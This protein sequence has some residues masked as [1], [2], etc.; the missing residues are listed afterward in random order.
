MTAGAP[1]APG[2]PRLSGVEPASVVTIILAGGAN[3]AVSA[4]KLVGAI[5]SGSAV[6][7]SEAAHSLADTVTEVMLFIAIRRGGRAA[8]DRHPLGH[9][10]ETYLW[11][12]LGALATFV[13]GAGV[14]F[15]EGESKLRR[16][17]APGDLTVSFVVLAVA[18]ALEGGSLLQSLRRVERNARRWHLRPRTYLRVT[19]DTTLKAVTFEDVGALVGLSLAAI[20]LILT[21]A[22]DSEVWDGIASMLIGVIL[23]A[24][25]L[26]L[27]RSNSGFLVGQSAR[28]AIE[29]QLRADLQSLPEIISVSL[30]FTSVLGPEQLIVA[31][32]V[33]FADGLTSTDI[34]RVADEAE[35]RFLLTHA[36]IKAVFLD[37]SRTSRHPPARSTP[38]R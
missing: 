31:A 26:A 3:L 23:L 5:T 22:T 9:G 25:A 14:S 34:T 19:T 15:A 2:A 16:Q 35:R 6:M 38:D 17:G 13:G 37:P 21:E 24:I 1:E 7:L 11:A 33:E 30:L 10:R 12:L 20:G 4:A 18:F 36:G 8:D 32:K 28:P 27:A 29:A